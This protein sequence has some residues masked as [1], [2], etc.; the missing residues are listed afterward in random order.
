MHFDCRILLRRTKRFARVGP[1]SSMSPLIWIQPATRRAFFYPERPGSSA[2]PASKPCTRAD[3]L[4]ASAHRLR[5]VVQKP[6]IDIR[7]ERRILKNT[8]TW[9][10]ARIEAK[11]R[12]CWTQCRKKI[13]GQPDFCKRGGVDVN[14]ACANLS[15]VV[16]GTGSRPMMRAAPGKPQKSRSIG[17]LFALPGCLP[18]R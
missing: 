1:V 4:R 7:R 16:V 6:P 17:A 9:R 5:A 14:W 10:F 13:Y 12:S 3:L 11:A 18:G 15:G 2:G 8:V